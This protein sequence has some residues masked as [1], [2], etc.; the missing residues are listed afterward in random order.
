[1]Q[2]ELRPVL[3]NLPLGP[4]DLHKRQFW[5]FG[6]MA[7]QW[8][9]RQVDASIGADCF[10]AAQ[11]HEF[12][13]E[14]I[15]FVRKMS[16][17][18]AAGS[19]VLTLMILLVS[20]GTPQFAHALAWFIALQAANLAFLFVPAIRQK[21]GMAKPAPTAVVRHITLHA[22]IMG[23]FWSLPP[24]LLLP[25]AGQ[26]LK[27]VVSLSVGG[28]LFGVCLGLSML[29]KAALAF[30]IPVTAGAVAGIVIDGDL[31]Y[32]IP[33]LVL[34]SL[35]VGVAP[36]MT[37]LACR[38]AVNQIIA[39][40]AIREQGKMVGLLLKE[41][42]ENANDW[43]WEF[44]PSGQILRVSPRFQEA[45][46]ISLAE[47]AARNFP[48]LLAQISASSE[49]YARFESLVA[50]REAFR[51]LEIPVKLKGVDRWWRL[52]GKPGFD[53]DGRYCGYIGICSE[54][55]A[56][57]AAVIEMSM[58]AH[59][60][61]LTGLMNRARFNEEMDNAVAALERYATPFAVMFLDL[62]KFKLVNDTRGHLVG[63]K[64][65]RAVADR[66]A[67]CVRETDRVARLGGDEFAILMLEKCDAG[68]AAKLAARLVVELAG[69]FDIDGER[70]KIGVSVG[71]ALAP[72]NGTQPSQLLRNA[73][74]AL[75]RSKADGRGVFRFFEAQMD[76]D[77]REKRLLEQEL[78]SAIDNG[79]FELMYQPQVSPVTNAP[80]GMEAL[81]RWHHPIRGMVSPLEFIPIAE[82]S[83]LIQEIGN[84][85]LRKACE[86]ALDWPDDVVVAVNLSA[87][88]FIGSDIVNYAREALEATG[89]P[90]HRLEL[91]ITESLLINNTGEALRILKDLKKLGITIALDDFGTG[92]SSLSYILKFPFDKIKIDRSFVMAVGEDESAKAILRMISSLGESLN[93]SITAEGVETAEQVEFLRSIRCDQFQGYLY[94]KPL[95]IGDLPGYFLRQAAENLQAAQGRNTRKIAV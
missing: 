87:H 28:I 69:H 77:Q 10:N 71:I 26:V 89:L 8:I 22:A 27:L 76:A 70:H 46:G 95:K 5:A 17:A 48:N 55:T 7:F 32:G 85:T 50:N 33:V 67:G 86:A 38:G 81:I 92:Y 29:P 44:D 72:I 66:I 19:A 61:A 93:I 64:L 18:L 78:R 39:R 37:M 68:A 25:D 63:D 57:K 4:I 47:L 34:L 84:W 9:L 83:T 36:N 6:C 30:F 74:L 12:A 20:F 94:S 54:I 75:Y 60:D 49:Q 11:R 65:L 24:L 45:T 21:T 15:K 35:L 2:P 79:E 43:L 1:M 23:L 90:A 88:H 53:H 31:S 13:S 82:Q 80:T 58:M 56:E 40:L 14:Q 16:P 3:N 62:D 59:S 52:T 42:E 91:E 51:E 41:F 73:D